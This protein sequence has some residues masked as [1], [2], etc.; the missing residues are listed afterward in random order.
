MGWFV[1]WFSYVAIV[2]EFEREKKKRGAGDF[3]VWFEMKSYGLCDL[4]ANW[5]K[6]LLTHYHC[7]VFIFFL[8][9]YVFPSII[10][11]WFFIKKI[12]KTNPIQHIET[13][14][15][16]IH[17]IMKVNLVHVVCNT[18]TIYILHTYYIS[19]LFERKKR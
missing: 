1:L 9:S 4:I 13:I 10:A 2:E 16:D 14:H 18:S 7:H 12:I 5:L 15:E 19:H 17:V 3:L 11:S 6:S 8:S